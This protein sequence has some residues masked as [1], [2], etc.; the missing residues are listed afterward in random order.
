VAESNDE[1]AKP[2]K[3]EV[4]PGIIKNTFAEKRNVTQALRTG[5]ISD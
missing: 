3:K 4:L 2:I 1:I 5:E